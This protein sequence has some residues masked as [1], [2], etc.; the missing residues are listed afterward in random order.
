V[1]D[2]D[3]QPTADFDKSP[4]EK[5]RM[6]PRQPDMFVYALRLVLHA[7]ARVWLRVYH[8]FSIRG[9]EHLPHDEPF[10]M[11]ANHA[12]HLD[13]ICMLSA[14]PLRRIQK[15]Y[16]AAAKDYFF[17]TMP[18]IAFFAV[19]MN[20]MPFDRKE[21]P[22]ESLDICRQLLST[23][24]HALIVFPE[25]TRS[26]NGEIAPFKVGVGFLTA[27]TN[28]K[29]VPC[30]ID[31]AYRAWPKGAW[32]PRPRKLALRIGAPVTFAEVT[33]DKEGAKQIAACLEALVKG[34]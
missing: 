13:A 16:P 4:L 24:G 7:I 17:T 32:I 10:V 22:R 33:A 5:L 34:L 15:A 14:F 18:K 21:N 29:V 31:G 11:V 12:S 27:G 25:G 9:R 19:T 30:R 3:Y 6:F 26:A 20:A 2:W 28:I 23:P 1:S 8:R